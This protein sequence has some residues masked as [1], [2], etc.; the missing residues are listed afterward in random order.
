M[1]FWS[2]QWWKAN[3]PDN[4]SQ[5]KMGLELRAICLYKNTMKKKSEVIS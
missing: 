3:E 1:N 5:F 2:L 4:T